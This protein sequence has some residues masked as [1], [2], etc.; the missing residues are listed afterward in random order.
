MDQI[1]YSYSSSSSPSTSSSSNNLPPKTTKSTRKSYTNSLHSVR[2]PTQKP[3]TKQFI[4]PMPPTPHR[5]Y[6]VNSSNFKQ[7]V[8]ML[9]SSPEFQSPPLHHLKDLAPPPLTLSTIPKPPLFPPSPPPPPLSSFDPLEVKIM[10]PFGLDLSPSSLSWCSSVILS[11]NNL[12]GLNQSP[13]I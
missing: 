5:V 8:H 6:N 12:S 13:V 9:T 2:K 4:A 3:I 11:P 1:T 7:V 10:S